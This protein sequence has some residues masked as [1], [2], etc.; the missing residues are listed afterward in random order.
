MLVRAPVV[1]VIMRLI[2]IMRVMMV[3]MNLVDEASLF[4]QRMRS[5]RRPYGRHSANMHR[6]N[7]TSA[8]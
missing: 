8:A 5:H 4:E 2:V 1:V 6:T 7:L 3:R